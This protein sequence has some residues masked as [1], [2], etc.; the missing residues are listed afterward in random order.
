MLLVMALSNTV[1]SQAVQLQEAS[2]AVRSTNC[3]VCCRSATAVHSSAHLLSASNSSSGW[4][5]PHCWQNLLSTP[6]TLAHM[7]DRCT[8]QTLCRW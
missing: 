2:P 7:A 6:L 5:L 1:S 8:A 3:R 4:N